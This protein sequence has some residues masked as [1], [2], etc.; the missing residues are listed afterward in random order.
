MRRLLALL[1]V[2]ILLVPAS[3]FA[4]AWTD[5]WTGVGGAAPEIRPGNVAYIVLP[6]AARF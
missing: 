2:F 1:S 4:A 6:N 3:A 5:L